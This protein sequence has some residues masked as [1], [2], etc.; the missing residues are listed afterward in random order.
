MTATAH[1]LVGGVVASSVQNPALG[2]ALSAISHPLLDLV[3]HW[4]FGINWRKKPKTKLFLEA[5]GDLAF[6]V[7]LS[8]FLFG[9]NVNFWYFLA[10]IF[11]SEVW[12]MLEAPYWFLKWR[13]PPLSWVYQI[14]SRMQGR[15]KLPW[16]II[17]QVVAIFVIVYIFQSLSI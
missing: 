5:V 1:A 14:Q 2:I 8:Y 6:G 7:T 11:V 16:G 3:P 12:D 15:A 4:D 13:F 9:Q 17:T 10:C